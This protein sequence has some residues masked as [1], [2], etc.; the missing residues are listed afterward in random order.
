M[1]GKM[2]GRTQLIP[3]RM[4]GVMVVSEQQ[5]MEKNNRYHGQ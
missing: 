4:K 5:V 1:I 2:Q 3:L